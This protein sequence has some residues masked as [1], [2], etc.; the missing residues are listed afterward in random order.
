MLRMLVL[1]DEVFV[2]DYQAL[3]GADAQDVRAD[4]SNVCKDG[5]IVDADAWNGL[6]ARRVSAY[7]QN[8]VANKI[9]NK[10]YTNSN[11]I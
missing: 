4:A 2:Q 7:P 6:D 3:V 5:W 8:I 10:R 9:N 11:A 1:I